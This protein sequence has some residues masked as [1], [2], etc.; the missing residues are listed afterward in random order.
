MAMRACLGLGRSSFRQP[1]LVSPFYSSNVRYSSYLRPLSMNQ[2]DFPSSSRLTISYRNNSTF[3]GSMKTDIS[4][5]LANQ[6]NLEETIAGWENEIDLPNLDITIEKTGFEKKRYKDICSRLN[7][8]IAL[9]TKLHGNQDEQTIL[10]NALLAAC[11]RV[12]GK[13][14]AALNIIVQ[15]QALTEAIILPQY[16]SRPTEDINGLGLFAAVAEEHARVLIAKKEVT[17]AI[18]QINNAVNFIKTS[19][20][21]VVHK[22]QYGNELSSLYNL[23]ADCLI[24]VKDYD[25]ARK[26]IASCEDALTKVDRSLAIYPVLSHF[27]STNYSTLTTLLQK[28]K[29]YGY[30]S[31]WPKAFYTL[32]KAE[33]LATDYFGRESVEFFETSVEMLLLSSKCVGDKISYEEFSEQFENCLEKGKEMDAKIIEKYG[34]DKRIKYPYFNLI[35]RALEVTLPNTNLRTQSI[36]LL[37]ECLRLHEEYP[38]IFPTNSEDIFTK[39]MALV[40]L[41]RDEEQFDDALKIISKYKDQ[42][43]S[44]EE[45]DPNYV[46]PLIEVQAQLLISSCYKGNPVLGKSVPLKDQMKLTTQTRTAVEGLE[47]VEKLYAKKKNLSG[48]IRSLH[49]LALVELLQEEYS[50]AERDS[51]RCLKLIDNSF[52]EFENHI[53]VSDSLSKNN[54]GRVCDL[55][56][57]RGSALRVMHEPNRSIQHFKKAVELLSTPRDEEEGKELPQVNIKEEMSKAGDVIKCLE[58]MIEISESTLTEL[59]S[60]NNEEKIQETENFINSCKT[61]HQQAIEELNRLS[62]NIDK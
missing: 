10:A 60:S 57:L 27:R 32:G 16:Q 5:S 30:K 12:V 22:F 31:Q 14:D 25:E 53:N 7:D 35:I 23:L 47:F 4:K 29:I 34:L 18:T 2:Y 42:F 13:Y 36:G 51:F 54:I 56:M 26:V 8:I 3:V 62:L 1:R 50:Y 11:Y 44:L 55:L 58:S 49:T 20:Q 43:M 37:L 9:R 21:Y 19:N 24:K 52:K 15:C 17:Q 40:Q 39:V 28:A 6:V 48:R 61:H 38:S 45:K 46:V 59:K 41:L 33:K